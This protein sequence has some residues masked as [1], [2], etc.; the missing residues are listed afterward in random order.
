MWFVT[1]FVVLKSIEFGRFD[2]SF[3]IYRCQKLVRRDCG[4]QPSD[5]LKEKCKLLLFSSILK[6]LQS[7]VSQHVGDTSSDAVFVIL[8]DETS[9]MSLDV[10][11]LANVVLLVWVPDYIAAF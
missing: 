9:C 11:W 4:G 7:E 3:G 6:R 2:Q 8:V 1:I 10:F 5:C